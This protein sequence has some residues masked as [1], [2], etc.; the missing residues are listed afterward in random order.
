MHHL[1]LIDREY[2]DNFNFIYKSASYIRYAMVSKESFNNLPDSISSMGFYAYSSTNVMDENIKVEKD[3]ALILIRDHPFKDDKNII[4]LFNQLIKTPKT[5]TS[6]I[7][8]KGN[9]SL[10]YNDSSN[11]D[12]LFYSVE[13]NISCLRLFEDIN[14]FET[15]EIFSQIINQKF[16]LIYNEK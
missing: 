13:S 14:S 6:F 11:I 5:F 7:L 3:Y 4:Y 12:K 8:N 2:M 10:I 1:Y 16:I 9:Y 15:G